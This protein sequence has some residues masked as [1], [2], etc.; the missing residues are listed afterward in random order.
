MNAQRSSLRPSACR[1]LLPAP[2]Q[3]R[4]SMPPSRKRFS[5]PPGRKAR[6]ASRCR[7]CSAAGAPERWPRFGSDLRLKRILQRELNHPRRAGGD[8]LAEVR[9]RHTCDRIA[10]IHAIEQVE[11]LRSKLNG[12]PPPQSHVL[13]EPEIDVREPG[14]AE[15]VPPRSEERRVGKECRSRWAADQY[16]E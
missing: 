6:S 3:V 4:S 13:H 10:E 11:E 12:V 15:D 7:R 1:R 9:R 2:L 16:K 5:E 8:D 14:T